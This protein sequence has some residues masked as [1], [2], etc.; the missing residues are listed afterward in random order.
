M[1]NI[2][3]LH[4]HPRYQREKNLK[5][6]W[7]ASKK[8]PLVGLFLCSVCTETTTILTSHNDWLISDILTGYFDVCSKHPEF[9]L[10]PA[11]M[12]SRGWMGRVYTSYMLLHLSQWWKKQNKWFWWRESRFYGFRTKRKIRTL[13][14]EILPLIK[15]I[16]N[17]CIGVR[18]HL[19]LSKHRMLLWQFESNHIMLNW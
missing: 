14:K 5:V 17:L 8:V 7:C 4:L 3:E 19:S 15:N 11:C 10:Q 18:I 2:N 9:E 12:S 6:R 13:L 1:W 16:E